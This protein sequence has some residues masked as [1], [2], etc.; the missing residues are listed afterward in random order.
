M[1]KKINVKSLVV[2]GVLGVVMVL[3]VLAVGQVKTF[4]SG[5][6]SGVEPQSVTTVSGDD[7]KS[8]VINWISDKESI[9]K[10]E[11]GTTAASLVLMSAE[12]SAVTNHSVSLTSLRPSTT[13]YFRIKVGE[14]VFDNGGI[15]Y[16]FK[17]KADT[18]LVTVTP[19]VTAVTPV[20]GSGTVCDPKV[21]YNNDGIVNSM[22][23]GSCKSSGGSVSSSGSGTTP[24]GSNT[25]ATNSCTGVIT[26]YNSDGIVN[27]LDRINCLQ[28]HN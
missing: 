2:F 1:K 14:D 28:S 5:A 8:A 17:T 22:D 24:T 26:D 19:T 3:V 20:V 10:I 25:T 4:M 11:Y 15:P 13:Y 18:T 27:S 12:S 23:L 7:G 21:D 9:S 6:T 16:T